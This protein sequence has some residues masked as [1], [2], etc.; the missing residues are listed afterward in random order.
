MSIIPYS[1][2]VRSLVYAMVCTCSDISHAVGVISR[3]LANPGKAH[4]EAVKWIFRYLRG[5]SKVCLSFG[6]SEPSRE[7]YIDSDMAGD[8]DCRKSTFGYLFTVAGGAISWQSKLQKCVSLSTT[9]A[10]Y[11]ATTEARKDRLWKAVSSRTR[12]KIERLHSVLR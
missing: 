4:W 11:I 3:F 8:L 6:E 7:S 10:K 1:S 5:T 9:E 12:F 2:V